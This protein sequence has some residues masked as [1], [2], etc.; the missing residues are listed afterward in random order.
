MTEKE[1][2][3][4]YKQLPI[5]DLVGLAIQLAIKLNYQAGIESIRMNCEFWGKEAM[6]DD[7]CRFLAA[8]DKMSEYNL[9]MFL[10][11]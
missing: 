8:G 5:D 7:L 2:Y 6:R 4:K 11:D 1:L 10:N 3:Q 9:I